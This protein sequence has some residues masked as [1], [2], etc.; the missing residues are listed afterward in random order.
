M[1]IKKI[2]SNLIS[3][4]QVIKNSKF[5]LDTLE[6]MY[7]SAS[8]LD[9]TFTPGTNYS[10]VSGSVQLIGST[11]RIYYYATRKSSLAAGNVTNEVVFTLK[12]T[13]D[14]IENIWNTSF[15]NGLTGPIAS[16][17]TGDITVTDNVWT[18]KVYLSACGQAL[19]AT[20]TV[21][22]MP[23]QINLDAY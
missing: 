5:N 14:K 19:S 7:G 12:I 13:S 3:N 20:E 8:V 21:F 6:K 2:F 18:I 11:L 1:N 22:L 9:A 16:F 23:A 15:F 17:Y 10:S 4:L